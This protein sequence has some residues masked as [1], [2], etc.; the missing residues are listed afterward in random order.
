MNRKSS[1]DR[2]AQKIANKAYL[3]ELGRLQIELV[4]LQEWVRTQG[5]Q[6]W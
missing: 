5:L 4:K 1:K 2:A 6:A 3:A